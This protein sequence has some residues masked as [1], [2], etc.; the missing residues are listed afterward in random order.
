[1]CSRTQPDLG[2][3]NMP[4]VYVAFIPANLGVNR[5][6]VGPTSIAPP[7]QSLAGRGNAFW[8]GSRITRT[9]YGV[10]HHKRAAENGKH[11]T[12]LP[13]STK[14]GRDAAPSEA[15]TPPQLDHVENTMTRHNMAVYY[16]S[17]SAE[18]AYRSF[19]YAPQK[20]TAR[21]RPC[22]LTVTPRPTYRSS[23]CNRHTCNRHTCNRL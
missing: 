1:M 11:G 9:L 14:V 16:D 5:A 2:A 19:P 7:G 23:T 20:H 21:A 4:C 22:A 13:Y 15:Q 10:W 8:T 12:T 18:D 17:F 6:A 3:K